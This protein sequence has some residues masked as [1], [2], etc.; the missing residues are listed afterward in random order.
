MSTKKSH[1]I[2]EK[3]SES[4]NTEK[5]KKLTIA[6]VLKGAPTPL[7]DTSSSCIPETPILECQIR[8]KINRLSITNIILKDQ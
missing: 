5:L 2:L 7:T 8:L 4:I 1:F 3:D 6:K